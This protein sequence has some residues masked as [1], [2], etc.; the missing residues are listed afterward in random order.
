VLDEMRQKREDDVFSIFF[1][2]SVFFA[3]LGDEDE[4]DFIVGE[5]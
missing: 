5:I 2:V 1:F 4:D 3:A